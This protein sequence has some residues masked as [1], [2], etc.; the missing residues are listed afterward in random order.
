MREN[1]HG[2]LE[3]PPAYLNGQMGYRETVDRR[4]L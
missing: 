2:R 3:L 4:L 1:K